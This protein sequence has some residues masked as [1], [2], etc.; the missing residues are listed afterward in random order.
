MSR[1]EAT[2]SRSQVQVDVADVCL[3]GAARRGS[4]MLQLFRVRVRTRQR[5]ARRVQ[6]YSTV[7]QMHSAVN[8][9]ASRRVAL[10]RNGTERSETKRIARTQSASAKESGE[11]SARKVKAGRRAGGRA[12]E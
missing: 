1:A 12:G 10:E 7:I 4:A 5:V 3:V 8:V 9:V 11:L 2:A 6:M